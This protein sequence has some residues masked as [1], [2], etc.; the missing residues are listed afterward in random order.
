MNKAPVETVVPS[1]QAPLEKELSS[2]TLL[3]GHEALKDGMSF[4]QTFKIDDSSGRRGGWR[5]WGRRGN[6]E[7]NGHSSEGAESGNDT[8]SLTTLKVECT[9]GPSLA[10]DFF[11]PAITNPSETAAK[12]EKDTEDGK[13][14]PGIPNSSLA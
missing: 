1:E 12:K 6:K 10:D 4:D 8:N 13:K 9:S 3:Q 14:D 5:P 11:I 7:D 2:S